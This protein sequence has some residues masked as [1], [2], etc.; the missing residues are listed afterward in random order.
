MSV[1]S[2]QRTGVGISRTFVS[3]MKVSITTLRPPLLLFS[4]AS[5][6]ITSFFFTK[7]EDGRGT[8][9]SVWIS[10]DTDRT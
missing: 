1:S 7:L 6:C 2:F 3:Q 10:R 9:I 5:R 4:G 8:L